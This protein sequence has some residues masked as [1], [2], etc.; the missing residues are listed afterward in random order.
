MAEEKKKKRKKKI[1]I[2]TQGPIDTKHISRILMGKATINDIINAVEMSVKITADHYLK[3]KGRKRVPP[4]FMTGMATF[5]QYST[6]QPFIS[7]AV[8]CMPRNIPCLPNN[9]RC[10]ERSAEEAC[11]RLI[12][13]HTK[14]KADHISAS[15]SRDPDRNYVGTAVMAYMA[16]G[17]GLI[18]GLVCPFLPKVAQEVIQEAAI[19][20]AFVTLNI[21]NVDNAKEMAKKHFIDS[22]EFFCSLPELS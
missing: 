12:L 17:D 14:M 11:H 7:S 8:V 3:G 20:L 16:E 1:N 18:I 2:P 5:F 21:I 15:E 6:G 13:M 4:F 19:Y 9:L 22:G 10:A